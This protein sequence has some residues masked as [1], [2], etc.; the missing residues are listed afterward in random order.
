M[1]IVMGAVG[2]GKSEQTKR[3]ANKL[4]C[5]R[6]STSQLLR[7]NLTPELEAK[8][9]AGEL[10]DDQ[11]VIELLGAELERL[12]ADHTELLLDGAPRS[13]TQAQWMLDKINSGKIMLTAII[14]LDVS[15]KVVL[16]RLSKRARQ[17]DKE[18]VIIKRL[19]AYESITNPVVDFFRHNGVLVHEIDGEVTP[20]EVEKEIAKVLGI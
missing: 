16:E 14:K 2:S 11:R 13:I 19:A 5:P 18:E 17:D 20:D 8:M 1:I 3:L 10:V 6:V 9:M 12:N 7:D 15:K 4:H